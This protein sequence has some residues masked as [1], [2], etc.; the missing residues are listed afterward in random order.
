MLLIIGIISQA[1]LYLCF[2][3]TLGSFILYLVPNTHRPDIHVPKGALMM[4]TGGIAI[5]SFFPVLQLILY[6]SPDIG[7][8]QTVKSVL[9][10]FEVGKSMDFH[11]HSIESIIYFC[12][13]V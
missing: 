7:L 1:L 6:L 4:A 2:S 11:L 13:L 9:F 10:T 12:H 3:L 8:V 5:F